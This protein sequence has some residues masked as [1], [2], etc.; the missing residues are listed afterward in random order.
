MQEE[1]CRW[2]PGFRY[3]GTDHLNLVL[4]VAILGKNST[5]VTFE[6]RSTSQA[7]AFQKM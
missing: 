1:N 5:P 3:L 7:Q 6:I 4:E 2:Y